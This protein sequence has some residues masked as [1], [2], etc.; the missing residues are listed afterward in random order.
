MIQKFLFIL[1]ILVAVVG[2]VPPTPTPAAPHEDTPETPPP[3]PS[4][5]PELISLLRSDD[6]AKRYWALRYLEGKGAEAQAAV[7]AL[8][9]N[10]KSDGSEVRILAANIL[11]EIGPPAQSA[12]P[13]LSEILL[14]DW[15]HPGSA[16]AKALGRIGD[17]SAIPALAQ[18]LDREEQV[19]IYS[20]EAIAILAHQDFPDIGETGFSI[21]PNGVPL[22]VEAAR[23]WWV[24]EGQYKYWK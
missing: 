24:Q 18:A 7:P 5:V 21:G 11:G 3:M 13:A 6:A 17:K 23:N 22:I 4:S 9:E 14:N 20:A 8:I 15:I 1:L 16:A 10:L 12:I 19:A 2:C